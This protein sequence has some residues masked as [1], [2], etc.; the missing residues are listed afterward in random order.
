[1]I[2]EMDVLQENFMDVIRHKSKLYIR[3]K[4][5]NTRMNFGPYNEVQLQAI[6]FLLKSVPEFQHVLNTLNS[7]AFS[8]RHAEVIEKLD[9]VIDNEIEIVS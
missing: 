7:S 2:K 9:N 5:G 6:S 4:D 1:M 3:L 8:H